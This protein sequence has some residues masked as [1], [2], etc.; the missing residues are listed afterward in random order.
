MNI[1]KKNFIYFILNTVIL[2]IFLPIHVLA[3]TNEQGPFISGT[4]DADIYN[5]VTNYENGTYQERNESNTVTPSKLFGSTR[6]TFDLNGTTEYLY[7]IKKIDNDTY[8]ATQ[9]ALYTSLRQE[10]QGTKNGVILFCRIVYD[11]KD[12]GQPYTFVKLQKVES[13][14]VRNN[15]LYWCEFLRMRYRVCGAAY[16]SN[17]SKMGYK[18]KETEYEDTS[19]ISSPVEGVAYSITGPNDYY[20]SMGA[21]YGAIAGFARGNITYR[22]SSSEYLEVSSALT[23]V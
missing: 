18:A 23:A 19:L 6:S 7:D 20:Y 12:F 9:V 15:N 16:N 14:V 4:I 5:M 1:L 10:S 3:D 2:F 17:G 8:A 22:L 11:E 13:G 21:A